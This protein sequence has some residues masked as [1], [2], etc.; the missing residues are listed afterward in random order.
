MGTARESPS[1]G[2]DKVG[3]VPS[4]MSE[5]RSTEPV[6]DSY[7]RHSQARGQGSFKELLCAKYD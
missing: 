4:P 2:W 6:S 7:H 3:K 1:Q 5:G